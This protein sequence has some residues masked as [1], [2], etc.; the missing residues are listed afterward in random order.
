MLLYYVATSASRKIITAQS[1][2]ECFSA[3]LICHR[4]IN[5]NDSTYYIIFIVAEAHKQVPGDKCAAPGTAL[6]YL[7]I[8]KPLMWGYKGDGMK[9]VKIMQRCLTVQWPRPAFHLSLAQFDSLLFFY[10]GYYHA[11]GHTGNIQKKN[12]SGT[13]KRNNSLPWTEAYMTVTSYTVSS[14][15]M[16]CAELVC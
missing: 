15:L 4:V 10:R 7:C 14:A 1:T 13:K 3:F 8:K 5:N 16:N 12:P 6:F 11:A 2:N 9:R